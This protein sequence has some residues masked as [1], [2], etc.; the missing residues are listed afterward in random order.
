M[1]TLIS[2][3][4]VFVNKLLVS[5]YSCLA[6]SPKKDNQPTASNTRGNAKHAEKHHHHSL[7]HQLTPV[8]NWHEGYNKKYYTDMLKCTMSKTNYNKQ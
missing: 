5:N 8:D 4:S 6:R 2:V 7:I 3:T 1:T